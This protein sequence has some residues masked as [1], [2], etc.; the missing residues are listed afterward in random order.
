M[1]NTFQ[2]VTEAAAKVDMLRRSL[3]SIDAPDFATRYNAT[4]ER[5]ETLRA[6]MVDALAEAESLL[7][8]RLVNHWS[9]VEAHAR[10]FDMKTV[11]WLT[12]MAERWGLDILAKMGAEGHGRRPDAWSDFDIAAALGRCAPLMLPVAMH[13][14]R[15]AREDGAG[16]L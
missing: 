2:D 11:E 7:A 13:M 3:R 16:G 15:T 8:S 5:V 1:G 12:G 9:S 4:D 14:A 6:E 10:Q